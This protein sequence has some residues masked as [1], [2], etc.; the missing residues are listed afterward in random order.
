MEEN[1]EYLVDI[2]QDFSKY[3]FCKVL[4]VRLEIIH[5]KHIFTEIFTKKS[6]D[7]NK[8]LNLIEWSL[9]DYME[10]MT[11]RMRKIH[12]FSREWEWDINKIKCGVGNTKKFFPILKMLENNGKLKTCI[13]LDFDGVMS[14]YNF[15]QFYLRMFDYHCDV[16]VNT[17]NPNIN[18]KWFTNHKY[19]PANKLFANKGKIKKI[20]R[21]IEISK[22]Y[23][24]CLYIDDEIEYLEYAW[25]FGI[26]AFH[27]T[28]NKIMQFT[29]KTK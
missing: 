21:L 29:M 18:E 9:F 8:Y 6:I 17:G 14:K 1:F 13:I 16:I 10:Y 20:K 3:G 28:Q 2:P 5:I 15:K 22:R 23:D 26:K 27:Y 24:N 7:I 12:H 4:L 25:I 11:N 19:I